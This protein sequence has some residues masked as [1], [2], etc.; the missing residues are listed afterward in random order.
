ME[1]DSEF[2]LQQES[3]EEDEIKGFYLNNN[4]QENTQFSLK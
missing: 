2:L 4:C 3:H 1:D